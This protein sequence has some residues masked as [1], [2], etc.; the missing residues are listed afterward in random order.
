MKPL[1]IAV[2]SLIENREEVVNYLI[3]NETKEVINKTK[4]VIL[5]GDLTRY[6]FVSSANKRGYKFDQIFIFEKQL[7]EIWSKNA[8]LI[9]QLRAN[10]A[11]SCVPEEFQVLSFRLD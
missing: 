2:V 4:E 3:N 6:Y 1:N 5:M 7:G 8:D 11:N 9:L 10:L